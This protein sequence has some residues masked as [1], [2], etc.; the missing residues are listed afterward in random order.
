MV[1]FF[2]AQDHVLFM[3]CY[4]IHDISLVLVF[5]DIDT[6]ACES[7]SSKTSIT[8]TCKRSNGVSTGRLAV[9]IM[10]PSFAFIYI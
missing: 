6:F 5:L 2:Q 1:F 4:K 9:T 8:F 3:T 7:V 10:R